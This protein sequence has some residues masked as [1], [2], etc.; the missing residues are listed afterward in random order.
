MFFRCNYGYQKVIANCE[1]GNRYGGV[2]AVSCGSSPMIAD[3]FRYSAFAISLGLSAIAV[4]TISDN[5]LI[6][7]VTSKKHLLR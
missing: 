7:I 5:F 6:A 2:F 4:L 3:I 1:Y